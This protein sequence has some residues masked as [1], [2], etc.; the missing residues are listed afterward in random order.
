MTQFNRKNPA[1]GTLDSGAAL[2]ILENRTREAQDVLARR[3]DAGEDVLHYLAAH[4]APATRAAVA[5][6]V[7]AGSATNRL[8]ADDSDAEVRAELAA[9]IARLLPGLSR[10]ENA[11]VFTLTVETLE[12]LAHDATASVRA[13]LAEEIKR[14]TCVPPDIIKRLARDA[15]ALVAAPILEYSPLLSDADLIEIIACAQTNEVLAAVARRHPVSEDV[16]A[17]IVKT[18]DIPAVAAL[19]VNPDARI[20][21][22]TL[23]HIALEAEDVSAWHLPLTLRADLS[24]RA[25][26]RIASFVGASLIEQLAARHDLSDT[27]R[28]H[29]SRELRARLAEQGAAQSAGTRPAELIA[30]AKA[31]GRLDSVFLEQAAQGGNRE[32]VTLTLAELSGVEEAK[33]RRILAAGNAKPVVALIWHAHLAMRSA[34]KIQTYVMRLPAHELLPARGGIN[35]PLSKEEM[36]WHLNYFGIAV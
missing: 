31:A 2:A 14:L 4:G 12:R 18:L 28:Q 17:A 9:K 35:F 5:A 30:A 20:R 21:K 13:V 6:N 27:T 7:G 23:D 22:Q 34:F 25:I 36:R 3:S 24:A 29:L 16:S 15:Q 8:L 11:H 10:E 33:V 26:R 32:L 1:S 19:L